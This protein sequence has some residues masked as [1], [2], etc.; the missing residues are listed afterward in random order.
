MILYYIDKNVFFPLRK[1]L[2][3]TC[4][5]LLNYKD[6]K[7]R[8]EHWSASTY[9]EYKERLDDLKLSIWDRLVYFKTTTGGTTG[10]AKTILM[11]RLRFIKELYFMYG[12]WQRTGWNYELRLTIR[13]STIGR[14]KYSFRPFSGE[15]VVNGFHFNDKDIAFIRRILNDFKIGYI[16]AYP[17]SLAAILVNDESLFDGRTLFFSSES[18]EKNL[19]RILES[20]GIVYV[21]YYGQTEKIIMAYSCKAGKD[22]MHFPKNYGVVTARREGRLIELLA[23][24]NY[25]KKLPVCGY[26]TDDY[27]EHFYSEFNCEC[28][29]N[30]PTS[31]LILSK[32]SK[33]DINLVFSEG[34]VSVTA[35]NPHS[36]MLQNCTYIQYEKCLDNL[37]VWVT[38]KLDDK[39]RER[40][41]RYYYERLPQGVSLKLE[42][43][44]NPI[45][46]K[47]GKSKLILKN[48]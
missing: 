31:S 45:K 34:K 27:V 9:T 36:T 8:D 23:S 12:V 10:M 42:I 19:R 5:S 44:N 48:E 39:M 16:Q 3:T 7:V 33:E 29:F 21:D 17:S 13:N 38:G 22:L 30:G 35:L 37:T 14:N 6:Q 26:R 40:L 18:L 2:Y 32:R 47:N 46:L 24:S 28:G 41:F 20:R 43:V 1:V 15:I 25:I 11:K 4:F